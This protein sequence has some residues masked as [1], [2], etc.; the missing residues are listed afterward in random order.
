M[1]VIVSIGACVTALMPWLTKRRQ[2]KSE[3]KLSSD[4]K[5]TIQG[6]SQTADQ[7]YTKWNWIVFYN[8]PVREAGDNFLYEM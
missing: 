5:E 6:N 7:N 1:G 4:T 3:S 8:G 2:Q